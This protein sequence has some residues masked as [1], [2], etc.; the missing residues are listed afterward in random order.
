MSCQAAARGT[1]RTARKTAA[2]VS[3]RG[4]EGRPRGRPAPSR[5][6]RRK[7][8][9]RGSEPGC[10]GLSSVRSLAPAH[11][12]PASDAQG[13][14]DHRAGH[15]QEEG[16]DEPREERLSR[17]ALRDRDEPGDTGRDTTSP[18]TF[19]SLAAYPTTKWRT[20]RTPRA[21]RVDPVRGR[22][23]QV[24]HEGSDAHD[25][26]GYAVPVSHYCYV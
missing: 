14:E 22:Q 11:D 4:P 9:Q 13:H 3:T 21:M 12:S 24:H 20:A 5:S 18:R 26:D 25:V 16:A 7:K 10:R 1:S 8:R 19:M 23:R 15:A 6:L 17:C 2:P